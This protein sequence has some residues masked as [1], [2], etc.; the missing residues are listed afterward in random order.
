M[1]TDLTTLKER[2]LAA[3]KGSDVGAS[4]SDV[5]LEPAQDDEGADFLRVIV[6]VKDVEKAGDEAFEALLERIEG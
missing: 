3:A 1:L 5:I 2:V 6:Q 4:V